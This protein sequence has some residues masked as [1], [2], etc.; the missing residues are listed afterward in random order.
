MSIANSNQISSAGFVLLTRLFAGL[1]RAGRIIDVIWFQKNPDYA[2]AILQ[3]A[4]EDD[5]EAVRKIGAELKVLLRDFLAPIAVA[6]Q[7]PPPERSTPGPDSLVSDGLA[8]DRYV[9]R[10]R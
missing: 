3:L 4:A 8:P 10:L 6:P 2:R 1:K 9:G 5:D 7:Q